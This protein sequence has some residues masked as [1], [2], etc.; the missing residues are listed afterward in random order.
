MAT[1]AML[2]GGGPAPGLNGVLQAV[3]Q[4][5]LARGWRVLGVP[6]GFKPLLAGDL[7]K[8]RELHARDVE[9]IGRR[10]GS[11]LFTS[12]ANPAKEPDG[13]RKVVAGL[14]QL[15]VDSLVTIGGDDTAT[16]AAKIAAASQGLRVAHVPKTIDNDLPLPGGA[17][18]FGFETA[19]ELGAQLMGNLAED[20]RT[21]RRFYL[22]TIMGRSAGHLAAGVG[23]AAGAD[24]TLVPE[25][26]A[27]Q[28]GLREI[29]DRV[30]VAVVKRLREG[31]PH[32][33]IALAEGLLLRVRPGDLAALPSLE[34]DEHGNP[35]I[36]EISLGAL[37]KGQLGPRLKQRGLKVD[38]VAK[39]LGYELR[40]QDPNA[41]DAAYTRALGL[42]AVEFL[43]SGQ[44]HA[45]IALQEGQLKPLALDALQ[46][47]ATGKVRVRAFDPKGS[48]WQAH[49]RLEARLWRSD[50]QG[51]R[52]GALAKAAKLDEKQFLERF[53]DLAEA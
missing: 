17:P 50:L 52:L 29:V 38:F 53:G 4:A 44:G 24:L 15:G 39:E 6:E 16:S 36:S 37:V 51:E 14:G 8:V 31:Q 19:R 43:A 40:C 12:R 33:A 30:E 46:D 49:R 22:V 21:T 41:F 13:V 10:G 7:G 2:V 28:I 47:A 11:V 20:A 48:A 5:S 32:G 1:L 35:R 18:T 45:M 9:G 42:G 27:L 26:F 3:T 23:M 25:E 34:K